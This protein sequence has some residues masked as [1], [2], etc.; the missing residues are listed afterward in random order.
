MRR[1]RFMSWL[2]LALSLALLGSQDFR[3]ALQAPIW[4]YRSLE[5]IRAETASFNG[6]PAPAALAILSPGQMAEL[7]RD[8]D[9]GDARAAAFLAL[10]LPAEQQAEKL[11]RAQ[12]AT[13]RDPSLFWVALELLQGPDGRDTESTS[14][15]LTQLETADPDNALPRVARAEFIRRHTPGTPIYLGLNNVAALEAALGEKEWM[16]ASD[17]AFRA[18]RYNA[19]EL[20]RFLLYRSVLSERGWLSPWMLVAQSSERL[21][22]AFSAR[23]YANLQVYIA[24]K[25]EKA[26]QLENAIR[27]RYVV[28]NFGGVIRQG[29][30]LLLEQLI[31]ANLEKIAGPGLAA[32]LDKV[33]RHEEATGIRQRVAAG[34]ALYSHAKDPFAKTTNRPWATMLMH[35]FFAGVIVFGALSGLCLIYA[36]AKL[37]VRPDHRGRLYDFMAV[38]ENYSAILLLIC[39]FGLLLTY[40]PYAENFRSYTSATSGMHDMEGLRS[41]SVPMQDDFKFDG[42]LPNP[43]AGYVFWAVAAALLATLLALLDGRRADAPARARAASMGRKL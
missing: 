13:E 11:R 12:E 8:A 43:L 31:G 9:R 35:T 38:L 10:Q 27:R 7:A 28:A 15:L 30:P 34:D 17:R 42:P 20:E 21:R 33:G 36:L 23:S 29:G 22:N 6:A 24:G 5:F 16:A 19:Y 39:C 4:D 14:R 1:T 40:A 32:D 37:V 3:W 18:P 2:F 26:G 25:E 41:S